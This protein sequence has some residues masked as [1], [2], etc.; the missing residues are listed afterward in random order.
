M[1]YITTKDMLPF[2]N[3]ELEHAEKILEKFGSQRFASEDYYYNVVYKKIFDGSKDDIRFRK[4]K[5]L[6][7]EFNDIVFDGTDGISSTLF[8]C[9]L[10]G[11]QMNNAGFNMS[12]FTQSHFI[13]SKQNIKI[14]NSS[15]TDSN[16]MECYFKNVQFEGC[17]FQNSSFEDATFDTCTFICCNFENAKFKHTT[18]K[19]IDLTTV[20]ID[21]AEFDDV[22]ITN[23]T[24]SYWGILWSFGGLQT[25]KKYKESVKLGLPNSSEYIIG[26]DFLN[27][28]KQIEAHFYY[29]KDFFSLTNINIYLG[30]QKKAFEYA[31]NGL[32]YNLQI[33]DFRMIKYL[34]KLASK[35][36]FFTKEYLGQLYYALQSYEILKSTTS[37]EYKIYMNEMSDLKRL[38]IDNPFG[39]PQ[40]VI[41]ITTNINEDES[42]LLVELLN[43][44]EEVILKTAA[45]SSHY[46]TLRHNSP[47]F[48]ELF[49]SD[50]LIN[51]Y[52]L[53]IGLVLG[54]WGQIPQINS[55]LAALVNV[56]KI[57]SGEFSITKKIREE[58]HQLKKEEL[59][60]Q[61]IT[62][63]LLLLEKEKKEGEIQYQKL[64]NELLKLELEKKNRELKDV[65]DTQLD[66]NALMDSLLCNIV[67]IPTQVQERIVNISYSIHT[68]ET[69]P[70]A[71]RENSIQKPNE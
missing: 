30:N 32:M 6:E 14:V 44:L 34:C 52:Q 58:E 55:L 45:Q 37:Y 16:F 8:A 57:Q 64:K 11:C 19:N 17:S 26:V 54:L 53:L 24:F 25:I 3:V 12:E 38:L 13:P 69:L 21:F 23:T 31:K 59:K 63:D 9:I 66:N 36:L 2:S 29:K 42:G 65:T 48:L 61:Q 51:L 15:F 4:L 35:N 71:L 60:A 5:H 41:R 20:C 39:Q 50:T 68:E 18:F 49:D 27:Q 28:L 40:I 46:V 10:R 1:D 7:C 47:Y 43:Y 67:T 62:N 56:K 22:Q 33:K 70:F